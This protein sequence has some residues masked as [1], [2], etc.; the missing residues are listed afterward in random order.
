[1]SGYRYYHPPT[2]LQER[3][4]FSSVYLSVHVVSHG[5]ITHDALNLTV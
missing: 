4:G 2:K 1:M 5:P 3:N